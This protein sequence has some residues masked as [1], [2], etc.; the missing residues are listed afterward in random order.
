[1][2]LPSWLR[3][4]ASLLGRTPTRRKPASRVRAFR[5]RLETLE[6]RCVPATFIVTNTLDAGAGSFRQAIT[7]A[8]TNASGPNVIDFNIPT[9][10][11]GYQS[12]TDSFSIR[13]ATPLP[14]VG[15]DPAINAFHSVTID[16]Y[17]QSGARQNTL[18][19]RGH[20][21]GGPRRPVPVRR[22]RRPQDR[23]E[24]RGDVGQKQHDRLIRRT[25]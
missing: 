19:G 9:S 5:P 15:Y 16:G 21:R 17:S 20:P 18:K 1:M 4:L 3:P 6:D 8:N 13:P 23:V 22:R 24:R 12:A 25:R 14:F 2:S 10:D 7:D 11:A